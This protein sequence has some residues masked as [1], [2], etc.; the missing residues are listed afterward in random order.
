[1]ANTNIKNL[2]NRSDVPLRNTLTGNDL[3]P[4]LSANTIYVSSRNSMFSNV[5]SLSISSNGFVVRNKY[6]PANSNPSG[7][8]LGKFFYD[9][10]YLYIK[11]S[12]TVVKRA[13][14]LTFDQGGSDLPSTANN[15]GKFLYLNSNGV[16]VWDTIHEISSSDSELT[17]LDA[18]NKYMSSNQLEFP[19]ANTSIPSIIMPA[20]SY[21]RFGDGTVGGVSFKYNTGT[22]DTEV[23]KVDKSGPRAPQFK[24]KVYNLT[25]PMIGTVTLDCREFTTLTG[26]AGIGAVISPIFTGMEAGYD[27]RWTLKITNGGTAT[28]VWGS[29]IFENGVTPLLSTSGTDIIDF[30]CN[31]GSTIYGVLRYK[32]ESPS[33]D[34][35][36]IMISCPIKP[37][38]TGYFG[39]YQIPASGTLERVSILTDAVGSLSV[40]IY[41]STEA[42]YP[43]TLTILPSNL[44]MANTNKLIV[45]N[46]TGWN[47]TF[48]ENDILRIRVISYSGI[49][50]ATINLKVIK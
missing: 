42:S 7:V 2:N 9:S 34:S 43:P 45:T 5:S 32:E 16:V 36:K 48:T 28:F 30:W 41:K 12:N 25:G 31:D 4:V 23:F 6:T 3:I 22:S 13:K 46:F 33:P 49:T 50:S 1:M 40:Q 21:V 47:T 38:S 17:M 24:E 29:V 26:T 10:N 20:N 37:V 44:S 15:Q 27:A 18:Q 8:T 35:D 39:D 14:L 19:F 11:V